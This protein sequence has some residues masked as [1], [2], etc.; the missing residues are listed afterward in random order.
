M[1][2]ASPAQ[3]LPPGA[4]WAVVVALAVGFSGLMLAIIFVQR[5]Y[6]GLTNDN[7]EFSSASRSVKPGLVAAGIVSAWTW[8]AT[9]LQS[10]ATGYKFGIAGPLAYA[11]G[12]TVQVLLFA[13]IA[14]NLKLNAPFVNT[15]LQVVRVRWGKPLHILLTTFSLATN[16]LVSSMLI[17]GGSSTVNQLTGMPV[18]AAVWLTPIGIAGYVLIG[19]LR[20][21]LIA[22]YT[23]TAV[24][25]ALIL[26]FAFTV[27][28]ASPKIGSFSR[29]AE[30]LELAPKV[31]GNAAGSYLTM[32]SKPG[33]LFGII[34]VLG[35]FAAVFGDQ[36]YAQRAIA[37]KGDQA[38]KGFILGG[39]AWTAIPLGIATSLGLAARALTGQDPE[40]A[41]L[42][43]EQV[44]QGLPAPAA[45]AA[46]LGKSG[47]VM[48]LVLLFLAVTSAS[49][50]QLVAVSSVLS[51][52]VYQPYIN[53]AA[54]SRQLFFVS[55]AGIVAWAL[56]MSAFGTIFNYATI[57]MGWLYVAMGILVGPSVVS[58]FCCTTWSK[59]NRTSCFVAPIVAEIVAIAV[60]LGSAKGLE[61][62]V[63]ITSTSADYPLV[64][65]NLVAVLLPALIIVPW[66]LWKP[67]AYDWEATRSINAP[68]RNEAA[69]SSLTSSSEKIGD[70]DKDKISMPRGDDTAVATL[71]YDRL[72]TLRAAGLDPQALVAS[73]RL[74][75]RTALLLS[76]IL[77]ILVPAMACIPRT[78]SHAGFAA[79]GSIIIGWLFVTAFIVVVY[80]VWESRESLGAV[81]KGVV[82][83][84]TG[85]T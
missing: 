4:G 39:L 36:S 31:D 37:V 60:W 76:F 10:A 20:S 25:V 46:L 18:L 44:S 32:R 9:L 66:S 43:A 68:W 78:F 1:A 72:A 17:L 58:I 24:L 3:V 85:N 47:A 30:L 16:V 41:V 49:A 19:G 23:H 57:S 45:A 65:G 35:N 29:M 28:A 51:Y 6:S 81:I 75:V 54:T 70:G 38:T 82:K 22:D 69:P 64:A 26:A 55:H 71:E 83:D 67:E 73:R 77:L 56:A 59:A 84:L 53:P 27:Y 74:A 14:S 5:R 7:E 42:T 79:W 50:A 11:A 21:S 2:Q 12:A 33:L 15:F 80:P 34:N 40:M 62:E 63:T 52:D 61:G 8:S 13:V 48:M